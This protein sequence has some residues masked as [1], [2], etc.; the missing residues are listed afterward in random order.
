MIHIHVAPVF[1]TACPVLVDGSDPYAEVPCPPL[2]G[3]GVLTV[4]TDTPASGITAED[5]YPAFFQLNVTDADTVSFSVLPVNGWLCAE[6]G[7]SGLTGITTCDNAY[8]NSAV[9]LSGYL[10]ID[11]TT[12]QFAPTT[13][14]VFAPLVWENSEGDNLSSFTAVATNSGGST[15]QVVTTTVIEDDEG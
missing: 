8:E 7:T 1:D 3:L 5:E 9:D 11:A 12:D 4:T 2:L 6:T 14:F 15:T 10:H 13:Q